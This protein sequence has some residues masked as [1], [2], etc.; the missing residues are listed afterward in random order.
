[1]AGRGERGWGALIGR[2]KPRASHR[3]PIK[4]DRIPGLFRSFP[5][6]GGGGPF[7]RSE[8]RAIEGA[9][10]LAKSG[11]ERRAEDFPAIKQKGG[12]G[13]KTNKQTT[14]TREYKINRFFFLREVPRRRGRYRARGRVSSGAV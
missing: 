14:K 11:S 9:F 12:G 6:S 7:Q 10:L 3:T 8:R 2:L 1:M 13:G 5:L 4:G